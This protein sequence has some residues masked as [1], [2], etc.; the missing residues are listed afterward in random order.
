MFGLGEALAEHPWKKRTV[1]SEKKYAVKNT[2]VLFEDISA[3]ELLS[4]CWSVPK[5]HNG[6]KYQDPVVQK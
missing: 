3:K 2:I 4:G 6:E 5:G 1:D